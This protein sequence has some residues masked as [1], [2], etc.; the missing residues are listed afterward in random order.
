MFGDRQLSVLPFL[1]KKDLVK[2]QLKFNKRRI[3]VAQLPYH[4]TENDLESYFNTFGEIEKAFIVHNEN[5]KALLPYGHVIFSDQEGATKARKISTH[6][7][8]GKKV[9][10]KVHKINIQKKLGSE[11]QVAH[12]N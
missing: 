7:I 5:D 4:A 12:H 9:A 3:V 8:C 11:Q 1:E 6:F 10:I 2:S